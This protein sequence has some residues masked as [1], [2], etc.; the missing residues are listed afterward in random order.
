MNDNAQFLIDLQNALKAKSE[1]MDSVFMQDLLGNYRLLYT[2]VKNLYDNIT[3]KSLIHQDPYRMDK[4]IS[5][6]IV[7]PKSAFPE[8]EIPTILGERFSDYEVMLDFI[9][10]YYRFTVDSISIPQIKKLMDFNRVFEWSK[11]GSSDADSNT[12]SLGIVLNQLRTN[13]PT[14]LISLINDS[15]GKCVSASEK[16]NVMLNELAGFQKELYKGRLRKDIFEH[17]DFNKE[18]AYSSPEEEMNEIKRL[19]VKVVGKKAFYNDLV[20]EI[21]MEDQG[22]DA[23]RLRQQVLDKLQVQ[24]KAEKKT[25][26]GPDLKELLETSLVTLCALAPTLSQIN[27]K[28]KENFDL[29]YQ[30]KKTPITV[31]IQSLKK[32]LGIQPKEKIVEVPLTDAKTGSVT[33][34]KIH[35]NTFLSDNDRKIRLYNAILNKG[36]EYGK[37]TSS[38]E[39]VILQFINKQIGENQRL[40]VTLNALDD[41]FKKA[42]DISNRSK[43]KGLK[44]DLS[45]MHNSVINAN[46]KRGEY[47]SLL[48]ESEQMKKLGISK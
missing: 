21:I 18:K 16:I 3:K 26:K 47:V 5:E 7:P 2:C 1:W 13:A 17:P 6:I 41:Y 12:K 9:C 4:R 43:I 31:F 42:V 39:D 48:E 11:L 19:Y 29:L 33:M 30:K 28:L 27:D 45:A 10:T 35:V 8:T 46:K 20:S 38:P 36:A 23:L 25:K 40:F 15:Q 44:I 32:A 24:E 37:I 22:K 14:V 34:I